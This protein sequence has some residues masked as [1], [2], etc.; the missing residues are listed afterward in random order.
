MYVWIP[1]G[2]YI[3]KYDT[4]ENV[5]RSFYNIRL[6]ARR[7]ESCTAD[8]PPIMY[9]RAIVYIHTNIHSMEQK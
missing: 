9:V 2:K 3:K 4:K 7:C 5:A 8:T 6:I 1:Y